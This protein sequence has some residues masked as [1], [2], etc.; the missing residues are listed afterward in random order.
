MRENDAATG[1]TVATIGPFRG[2]GVW[3][4]ALSPDGSRIATSA[5]FRP[6]LKLLDVATGRRL[7]TLRGHTDRV[8]G[9]AF[10]PDGRRIAS[11]SEDKTVKIWDSATNQEV[12]TLRGHAAGVFG[13]AISPDGGRI[14]SISR[15]STVKLW[16][17]TTGREV[18]TFRGIVQYPSDYFGNAVAFHPDGRWIAAASDDGRVMA[19]DVE[20]G[21]EVHTL[22]G[23]NG[24][25]NAVAFS[26][27]GRRIASAGGD[28]AIKL[29][30]ADTGDEVFTLR[31][32]VQGILGLAFSPDG[33]RIASASTDTT[34]KIWDISSPTPEIVV[35]RRALSL[36]EPLFTKFLMREDVLESLHNNSTLS[37]PVR[38]RP[39]PWRN[40]IPLTRWASTTP[41]GASSG[42]PMPRR[43]RIAWPCDRP[44]SPAK[45]GRNTAYS[46]TLSGSP[47]TAWASTE[48]RRRR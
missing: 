32:H 6:D 5:E 24:E 11:A 7:A 15:D 20:T 39:W 4:L 3:G 44:R 28:G 18:R 31:G 14:A 26:P 29:W 36:V 1:E 12:R 17:V 40:V 21:R 42:G 47:S 37:E 43:R 23:H 9:V 27:D 25:V 38:A 45:T 30:D 10:S 22:V 41:V 19:W 2:G 13:V 8:R 35:R 48:R 46:S 33:N 34:V 16:D